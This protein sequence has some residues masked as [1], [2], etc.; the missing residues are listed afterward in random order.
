[1]HSHTTLRL[2]ALACLGACIGAPCLAQD[3]TYYYGGFSMGK[4]K[5]RLD[6][7]RMVDN[8]LPSGV[9]RSSIDTHDRAT[10]FK[11]F[12]G[13][14]FNRYFGM[15]LGYFDT[16]KFRFNANTS[17][18]GTVDGKFEVHGANLDMVGTLPITDSFA[19]IGRLGVQQAHTKDTFS[20]TGAA[21]VTNT[22]PSERHTAYKVGAGLQY[23]FSPAVMVRSEIERYRVSDALSNHGAINLLSVSLVFPFGRSPTA[24][25]YAAAPAYVPPAEPAYVAP[26]PAPVAAIVMEPPAAGPPP[27]KRV[28]FS[29][30]SLFGFDQSSVKPD[31]QAA[32]TTFSQSLAGTR[33]DTITVEGH[34]DRLGTPA[35]NQTLSEQRAESVKSYLVTSGIDPTKIQAVGKGEGSPITKAED[36]RGKQAKAKLVACLQPD[37]RVEVEVSGTQPGQQ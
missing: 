26:P 27:L 32:L 11:V 24:A 2:V 29:A 36:C 15:E 10:A 14:Q 5:E 4:A 7:G 23:A 17:P 37:R 20:G 18:T 19:A 28:S 9:A 8:V 16:G 13:Y 33:Y 34:T 1:M 25:K 31:G 6:T 21:L 30:E 35:Y 12:G 3:S 22:S